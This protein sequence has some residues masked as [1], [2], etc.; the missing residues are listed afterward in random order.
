MMAEQAGSGERQSAR[1]S[2][3]CGA[4]AG[5]LGEADAPAR[6]GRTSR[7]A[8]TAAPTQI[9]HATSATMQARARDGAEEPR[10]EV[11]ERGQDAG[12]EDGFRDAIER[13]AV[14]GPLMRSG[15]SSA[16]AARSPQTR[17]YTECSAL[18][19]LDRGALTI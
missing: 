18:S 8:R 19:R 11:P 5:V 15:Q 9:L 4:P 2:Q 7:P 10:M 13:D 16:P 12:D 3:A 6:T 17:E 14:E 1:M